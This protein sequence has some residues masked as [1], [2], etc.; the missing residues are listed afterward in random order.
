[1]KLHR[2]IFLLTLITQLGYSQTQIYTH[3]GVDQGLPSSEVYDIYQDKKGNIWFAT[4]KGLSRFNGYEF[5]NFTTENGLPDNTILDFYPQENGQVW[6]YGYHSQNLF[7]FNDE[8]DGFKNYKHNNVLKNVIKPNATVKSIGF[9]SDESINIG[10]YGIIGLIEIDKNGV[11]K[12]NYN[13]DKEVLSDEGHRLMQLGINKLNNVLFVIYHE[14]YKSTS[15][16]A[17]YSPKMPPMSGMSLIVQ[18]TEQYLLIDRHLGISDKKGK[19]KYYESNNY[20]IGIK[21]INDSL[22]FAGYYSAGAEIRHISGKIIQKFLSN[23]S[24]TNFLID[25]EGSYWFT[26]LNDGVFYVKNP[27]IKEHSKNHISSLV[28]DNNNRLFAGFY[29]GKI[30]EITKNDIKVIKNASNASKSLVEFDQINNELYGYS[31]GKLINY[32]NPKL[33]PEIGHLNSLPE[34]IGNPLLGSS[35]LLFKKIINDSVHYFRFN[36]KIQDVAMLRKDVL[37]G[38]AKGLYRQKDNQIKKHQPLS[39]LKSRIDDIDVNR[40]TNIAYMATQGSGLIVYGDSIYNIT[41][42]NGLTNNIVSEVYIEND[43]T[44]WACT[45]TGLNRIVFDNNKNYSISTITKNN[46]LLSNDIDDIE[47]INDTVWVATKQGLCYFKNDILADK[48]ASKI[49]SLKLK[50]VTVNNL[51]VYKTEKLKYNQNNIEFS[52]QAI[53]HKNT[54][55]IKYLYRL[56]EVDTSWAST[57]NRKI[58]F[59]SLSPGNYTFEAKASVLNNESSEHIVYS[60][61]ISP[62]FW[63]SWWFYSLC[64]ILIS[65]LIYLFFK[66]RVLTYNRDIIRELIRLAI[67]RLKRKEQFYNFRSNGEDFK[68]PTRNIQFINSQGNYLDI[69]TTKKTFTIR[70]KIG[71]FIETTPDKLEYVRVHRS[72]IIRIDKVSSKGRNWVKINDQKIPVGETYLGELDKIQF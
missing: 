52:V 12:N 68:I 21:R 62:P 9:N 49:I 39:A 7:Y 33:L 64:V 50:D 48:L 31:F 8:F 61:K 43:S 22:F 35:S 20:P 41:K 55:K 38:T 30:A 29:N 27:D 71:D 26:T 45:N 36:K 44:I 3:Y 53:S 34:D 59:P 51:C 24:V 37:I 6:C 42:K 28:K 65:G 16:I 5:E 23:K 10:G 66:I 17:V 72:Y 46:G 13:L 18:N 56:K 14:K 15:Q 57:A 25:I 67:K 54:N 70:C 47:I 2:L 63:K 19:V 69:V 4:D 1:L 60:F 40:K 32:T 58:N 11:Y